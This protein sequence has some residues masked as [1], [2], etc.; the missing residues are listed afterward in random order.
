VVSA[1]DKIV[2]GLKISSGRDDESRRGKELLKDKDRAGIKMPVLM[3]RARNEEVG[4]GIE[5]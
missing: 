3:D 1:D 5:L 4:Y 2:V